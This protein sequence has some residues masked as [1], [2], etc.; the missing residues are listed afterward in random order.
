[1]TRLTVNVKDDSKLQDVLRFLCDIDFLEVSQPVAEKVV[2][3][4]FSSIGLK[5]KG[6]RFDRN[7]ANER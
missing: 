2:R 1:M 3:K 7:M 4:S 5:T 6:F